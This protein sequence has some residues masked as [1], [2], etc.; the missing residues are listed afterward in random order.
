MIQ[1]PEIEDKI[2]DELNIYQDGMG[3]F[4]KDIAIRQRRNEYFDPGE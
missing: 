3:S 2:T 1:N 4:G